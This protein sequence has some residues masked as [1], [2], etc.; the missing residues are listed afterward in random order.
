MDFK[1]LVQGN[2]RHGCKNPCDCDEPAMTTASAWHTTTPHARR[3]VTVT[4]PDAL[5]RLVI[6][7]WNGTRTGGKITVICAIWELLYAQEIREQVV[8]VVEG[9]RLRKGHDAKRDAAATSL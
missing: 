2:G 3:I 8:D 9:E 6:A 4:V 5:N 7:N 1:E